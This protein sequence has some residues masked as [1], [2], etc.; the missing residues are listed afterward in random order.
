M[1]VI[2]YSYQTRE[3]VKQSEAIRQKCIELYKGKMHKD[4]GANST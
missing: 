2:K 3:D 4:K 1:Y